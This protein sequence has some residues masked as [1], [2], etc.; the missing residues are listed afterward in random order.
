MTDPISVIEVLGSKL[1][2]DKNAIVV[3]LEKSQGS[4]VVDHRSGK[5]YLDCFSQFASQALGW[6][7]PKM[8]AQKERL[9]NA[10]INKVANLSG[11]YAK[12]DATVLS[13]NVT[14]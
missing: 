13:G 11:V 4:W 14:D 1:L 3:D 10:A 2:I 6:N 5:R 8:V 12:A 9:A 7:H